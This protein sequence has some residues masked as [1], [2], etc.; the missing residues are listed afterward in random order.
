[1]KRSFSTSLRS[2]VLL[3]LTP[4]PL[5]ACSPTV[6]TSGGTGPCAWHFISGD[7]NNGGQVLFPCGLPAAP[8][9]QG[10][11]SYELCSGYCG[12]SMSFN[13]CEVETDAGYVGPAF[14][15]VDA[16]TAPTVVDCYQDHTGRRPA[17]LVPQADAGARSVGEV[18]ARAAYLEAAAVDA[19]RDLAG[20]LEAHGAPAALVKRLRRAA[21]EEVRHARDVG[22]LARARGGVPAPV[23]VEETGPRSV[24]A[25]ALENAREGCVRETWG[26]ACAVVQSERAEDPAVRALM[27]TIARDELGHA[28]LSWDM[29]AWLATRLSEEERA[30]VKEERARAVAELEDELAG[31]LPEPWAR[32]LGVPSRAEA[33]VIFASMRGAVWGSGGAA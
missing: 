6:E 26:A 5:V 1:M 30:L 31:A 20:Q 4:I 32:A 14:A 16:G 29:G 28:A 23:A 17:G 10:Q 7:P 15:D 33:R 21:R 9:D 25:L 22:A 19:F 8:T 3:A 11:T 2:L 24:L 13:S 12:G 27:Q 18:L